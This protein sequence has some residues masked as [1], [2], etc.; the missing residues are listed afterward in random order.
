VGPTR[1][2]DARSTRSG[3]RLASGPRLS[4]SLRVDEDWAALRDS[5]MGRLGQIGPCEAFLFPLFSFFSFISYFLFF[6]ISNLTLN[7]HL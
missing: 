2:R 7:L 6:Q 3:G 1:K 5:Q 4:A